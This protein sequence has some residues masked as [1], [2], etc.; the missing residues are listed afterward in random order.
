MLWAESLHIGAGMADA[1][2]PNNSTTTADSKPT[3]RT[4]AAWR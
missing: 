2:E 1:T 4:R 3:A